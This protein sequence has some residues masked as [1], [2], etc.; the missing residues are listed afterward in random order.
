[1]LGHIG[2]FAS[3]DG[4]VYQRADEVV[5]RTDR[6]LETG[7]VLCPLDDSADSS[8]ATESDGELLRRMTPEDHL[9][10]GRIERFRDSAFKACNKLIAGAG[11][12]A[13]LVDVEHLF[14]GQSLY[15]Y[16]LGAV[17]DSVHELTQS[18]AEEYERKVRFRKFTQTMAS[19]C[20]PDCGTESAKCSSGG[21][22]SC[23]ISS[24]CKSSSV[25]S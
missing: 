1:M 21:C 9:I 2:R 12:D 8:E 18:L 25:S 10:V 24:S 20:G 4:R 17:P 5:C 6:G 13:V 3:L 22:G 16:F 11:L 14:D 15:F 23:S 7:R 19:G